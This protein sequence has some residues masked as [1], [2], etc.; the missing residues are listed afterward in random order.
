MRKGSKG[1]E[2]GTGNTENEVICTHAFRGNNLC[3][4]TYRCNKYKI[5]Y[6]GWRRALGVN[7]RESGKDSWKIVNP[8]PP[9]PH[10]YA[11]HQFI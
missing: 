3:I 9:P 8:L 11:V 2:A 10:Y 4:C 5:S 1:G 6:K 7:R